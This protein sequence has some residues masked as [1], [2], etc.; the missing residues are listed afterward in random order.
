ME[1]RVKYSKCTTTSTNGRVSIN[2]T[3]RPKVTL[4][5]L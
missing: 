4:K 2:Q 1:K 3:L 5:E